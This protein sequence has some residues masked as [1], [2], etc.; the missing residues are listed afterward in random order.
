MTKYLPVLRIKSGTYDCVRRSIDGRRNY[1]SLLLGAN[2]QVS[3]VSRT[4]L[5]SVYCKFPTKRAT[6]TEARQPQSVLTSIDFIFSI[7]GACSNSL[8]DAEYDNVHYL[9]RLFK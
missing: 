6:S 8:T 7:P 4:L 3:M 9:D 1:C 2:E 5:R